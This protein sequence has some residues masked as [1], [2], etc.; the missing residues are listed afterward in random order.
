MRER[1]KAL[2]PGDKVIVSRGLYESVGVVLD[3]Y[4]PPGHKNVF[5]RVPIH[6]PS[7]KTLD[8]EDV[9]YPLRVV[10]AVAAA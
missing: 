7:G 3:V 4:G 5:V 8:E 10:R 6:G 2:K 1:P 9:S